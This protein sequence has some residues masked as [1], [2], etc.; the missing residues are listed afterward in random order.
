MK[1]IIT[2][3]TEED[4][5]SR[6][7]ATDNPVENIERIVPLQQLFDEFGVRPTYLVDYPVA[8][9]PK[10]VSVFKRILEEGKYEIG[11]HCHPWNT[12]LQ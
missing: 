6:Y 4:N 3:D 9:N 1:L 12:P 10:S 5:W 2:I 11:M 8:T 7:S